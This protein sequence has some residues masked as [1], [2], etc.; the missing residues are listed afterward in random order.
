[1]AL[2]RVLVV[3]GGPA[4]LSAAINAARVGHQVRLVEK[5]RIGENIRCAE[6]FFDPLKK[7][8]KPSAGV[9]FK[10]EKLIVSI[11]NTYEIDVRKLNLWRLDRRE[12][13]KSLAAEAL[14]E[15]V[16]IEENCPV[17]PKDLEV[18]KKDYDFIIDASGAPSVTSRAYGF[19]DFYK[20]NCG[21]TV[22][23]VMEGDFSHIGNNFKVGLLPGL[24]G[25]YWIFPKDRNS[26]N[27]GVGNFGREPVKLWNLLE[28]VL[29]REGL[30]GYRVVRELGGICPVRMLPRLTYDNILL[31]GDAAG[32]TS[33]LHGGGIDM[34]LLSGIYAAKSIVMGGK[35]Y[36]KNLRKLLLPRLEIELAASRMWEKLGF[37]KMEELVNKLVKT[38]LYRLLLNPTGLNILLFRTF[39]RILHYYP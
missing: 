16:V 34:A 31:V 19:S 15:G 35:F 2:A 7:L 33:P 39:A 37:D 20:Q 18:L 6:G 24:F 8:G 1:M 26:A 12:W 14:E 11:K 29:E 36:E 30:S 28:Q 38:G 13:Q 10:V 27:V 21:K 3:G 25:Y 5:D 22:Q 9:K 23:F 4:G 17:F 32:L